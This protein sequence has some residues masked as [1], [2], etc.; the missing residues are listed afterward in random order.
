MGAVLMMYAEVELLFAGCHAH[1]SA[2]GLTWPGPAVAIAGE[3]R[4]VIPRPTA[5]AVVARMDTARRFVVKCMAILSP[6]DIG[7][8]RS[9]SERTGDGC[10][11]V[12]VDLS[13][14]RGH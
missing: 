8:T 4:A 13:P 11:F 14:W 12:P 3:T 9:R 10:R 1:A 7:G 2:R 6:D 5:T